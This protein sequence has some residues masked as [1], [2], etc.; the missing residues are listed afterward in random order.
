MGLRHLSLLAIA[1]MTQIPTPAAAAE[2]FFA[3]KAA[4]A[5]PSRAISLIDKASVRTEADTRRRF[6][7]AQILETPVGGVAWLTTET[8]IDCS[9]RMYQTLSTDAFGPD[10]T[11]KARK[12]VP[13]PASAIPAGSSA[14]FFRAAVCDGDWSHVESIGVFSLPQ[15]RESIFTALRAEN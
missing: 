13:N 11:L 7:V 4:G 9:T 3:K 5:A 14:E 15:F 6:A 8:S 12:A 2:W 1:A 10:G